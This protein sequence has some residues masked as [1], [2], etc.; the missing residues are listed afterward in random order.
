MLS[1]WVAVCVVVTACVAMAKHPA[2]APPPN[3]D[4]QPGY[5][6][7]TLSS[8]QKAS[9]AD[10]RHRSS[11]QKAHSSGRHHP[12]PQPK[13]TTQSSPATKSEAQSA[14]PSYSVA[15][16]PAESPSIGSSYVKKLYQVAK[17]YDHCTFSLSVMHSEDR[18]HNEVKKTYPLEGTDMRPFGKPL[19]IELNLFYAPNGGR[20]EGDRPT[21]DVHAIALTMTPY[22][23]EKKEEDPPSAPKERDLIDTLQKKLPTSTIDGLLEDMEKILPS[24]PKKTK[25]YTLT[26]H[27]YAPKEPHQSLDA[28]NELRSKKINWFYCHFFG[29]KDQQ[30]PLFLPRLPL[31]CNLTD[32]FLASSEGA[33]PV[34]ENAHE[35]KSVNVII[36]NK[37]FFQRRH[38]KASSHISALP[39]HHDRTPASVKNPSTQKEGTT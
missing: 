19:S 14:S 35:M 10:P 9:H 16:S 33:V 24:S 6:R 25:A 29:C 18:P 5:M 2:Y 38:P 39:L 7:P 32:I 36:H 11:A 8:Q 27:I 34:P 15:S 37:T 28:L 31:L 23:S 30:T 3:K 1:R 12:K 26:Q 4:K 13:R 21:N 17:R 22:P 20:L